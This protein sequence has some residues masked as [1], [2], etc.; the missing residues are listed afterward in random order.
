MERQAVVTKVTDSELK[1]SVISPLEHA[2]LLK[3]QLY[4]RVFAKEVELGRFQ[5]GERMIFELVK[6]IFYQFHEDHN[7][8]TGTTALTVEW[9]TF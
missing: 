6:D 3:A 2:A 7:A 9:F 1:E 5:P 4:D 8:V